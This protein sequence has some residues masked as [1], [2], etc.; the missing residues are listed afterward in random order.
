MADLIN[1]T[2]RTLEIVNA[3]GI[4]APRASTLQTSL[5]KRLL[6]ICGNPRSGT[7]ALYRLVSAHRDILVGSELYIPAF[8][9]GDITAAYFQRDA[10]ASAI[11]DSPAGGDV[12]ALRARYDSAAIIGD[13]HPA[14]FRAY[15][16]LW[17]RFPDCELLYIVRNPLS[18]AESYNE[19]LKRDR[20]WQRGHNLALIEWNRSVT[21]TLAELDR[22]RNIIVVSYEQLFLSKDH[23]AKL[24]VALKLDPSRA[25][26]DAVA[27]C[28][29]EYRVVS[30][31]PVERNDILRSIVMMNAAFAPWRR[32]RREHCIFNHWDLVARKEIDAVRRKARI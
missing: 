14:L 17:D 18:V 19:R 22:S 24:F 2:A 32:L 21:E 16:Y 11:F 25:D 15:S 26:E 1:S 12:D 20:D 10:L 30:A 5:G 4:P 31:K 3:E 23:A 13:K 29:E 7:T 28:I 9:K 6:F 8:N 27:K